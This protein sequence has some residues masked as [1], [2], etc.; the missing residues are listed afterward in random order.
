VTPGVLIVT[1]GSV[2]AELVSAA[3]KIVTKEVS[4]AALALDWDDD[5]EAARERL[6]AAI[7]SVNRGKGVL[8]LTDMFGGTPTNLAMTFYAPG[9]VEV[10]TG[11]NLP[12]VVKAVTL[13]EGTALE[14]AARLLADKGRAAITVAGSLLES[15]GGS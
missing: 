11:V 4:L 6:A 14:E 1:H 9:D 10:V 5:V 13:K 15:P 7:A 3:T 2:A 12:M 8:I